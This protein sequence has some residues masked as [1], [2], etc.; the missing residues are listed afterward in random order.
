MERRR[1]LKTVGGA[2]GLFAFINSDSIRRVEAAV[3]NTAGL[4]PQMIARDESFWQE[5]Q[6][7]FTMDRSLINL[8]NA[9]TCPS[10][11][12]VTEAVVRYIWRQ[13]QIPSQQ[14][15]HD[16]EKR[17][18]TV[19]TGL[20]KLYGVPTE[21]VAILH[22]ATEALKTVLYGIELDAGDEVITTLWD[23]D[24]LRQTLMHR[25]ER[26]N[27]KPVIIDFS[28]PAESM[29]VLV[30]VFERAITPKTRLIMVS[31]MAYQN[32][33]VFPVKRIRDM[34]HQYGVEVLVDGAH[35]FAH[36][37]DTHQD[38]QADYYGT[39]LHKW[40][41]APKGT[42]MLHIPKDKIGKIKPLMTGN[43]P[44][45]RDSMEK[46]EYV[47]TKSM[48][49]F[50]AISE[51]ITFHNAIGSKRKEER[52]RYLTHYWAEQLQS[53]PK[54]RLYTSL[55][56]EASCGIATVGIEGTHPGSLRDY[57]WEEH[58]IQTSSRYR[59]GVIEGLRTSPNLYI[60]LPELDYFCEAMAHV[61]KNGLPEPYKSYKPQD[62]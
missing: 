17:W 2:A 25:K 48:A 37:A 21:E 38:I 27:I 45:W 41:F 19:K 30:E 1:F 51:A 23:Y 22:N 46:Y 50:M 43:W 20:A 3:Q 26:D 58:R 29:D 62:Q 53:I 4:T 14:W 12:V 36:L 13:E 42:G 7:A 44:E 33:Q 18:V 16:F 60:T 11:R 10:P 47:G 28:M 32:G 59:E 54:I 24:T 55:E 56:H 6:Q 15:I 40:L 5:V 49:P 39:S 52:L 57:L 31:H 61:A 34:A 8:D 35:S 9:W